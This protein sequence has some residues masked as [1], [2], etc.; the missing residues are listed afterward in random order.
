MP[1]GD[2]VAGGGKARG[3]RVADRSGDV[4]AE[5]PVP[6][7]D[8][9]AVLSDG[10]LRAVCVL[11]GRET[12]A[13]A[14]SSRPPASRPPG[15]VIA[16]SSATTRPPCRGRPTPVGRTRPRCPAKLRGRDPPVPGDVER[17]A[18][19]AA[20][21]LVLGPRH[22]GVAVVLV[23]NPRLVRGKSGPRAARA[24]RTRRPGARRRPDQGRVVRVA[25]VRVDRPHGDRVAEAVGRDLRLEGGDPP[26]RHGGRLTEAAH[27]RAEGEL[28]HGWSVTR[29]GSSGQCVAGAVH[30]DGGL[31]AESPGSDSVWPPPKVPPV[32]R[33]APCTRS[34]PPS[35]PVDHTI[36]ALS[37]AAMRGSNACSPA[38]ETVSGAEARSPAAGTTSR[39]AWSTRR[40]ASRPGGRCRVRRR[41]L[42][43]R[44][45]CP[46]CRRGS[47]RRRSC[48]RPAAGRLDE[49]GVVAP[50][51]SSANHTA[52]ALLRLSAATAARRPRGRP[53][54]CGRAPTSCPCAAGRRTGSRT[55]PWSST[56]RVELPRSSTATCGWYR[57]RGPE[58][59]CGAPKLPCLDRKAACTL[60]VLA[61]ARVQ[62]TVALSSTSTCGSRY[63]TPGSVPEIVRAG[64]KEPPAGR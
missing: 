47:R 59:V 28:D 26:G 5:S 23:G 43:D 4:V 40:I 54:R 62:T 35:N 14:G 11:A 27:T 53:A 34:G 38:G 6:G 20:A 16:P 33:N 9:R 64:P 7:D 13:R 31:V 63:W 36:A 39:R 29:R 32:G 51:S 19:R 41:S 42:A 24:R 37:S 45:R 10:N 49:V 52:T 15:G 30:R 50:G 56:P 2:R 12:S 8:R 18:A 48:R 17:G 60:C 44:T 3:R 55:C 61:S 1:G 21:V 57:R 25:E 22:D 58:I 46:R